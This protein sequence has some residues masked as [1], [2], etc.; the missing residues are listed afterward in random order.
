MHP[1]RRSSRRTCIPAG[2]A[3]EG[4]ASLQEEQ[5]KDMHLCRRSSRTCIS[6]GRALGAAS[7]QQEQRDVHWCRRSAGTCIPTR[8]V[9]GATL[10]QNPHPR[11]RSSR[12]TRIPAGGAAGHASPQEHRQDPQQH[13]STWISTSPHPAALLIAHRRWEAAEPRGD[14]SAE[15]GRNTAGVEREERLTFSLWMSSKAASSSP[16]FLPPLSTGCQERRGA[17]CRLGRHTQR[18]MNSSAP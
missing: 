18:P 12:G 8:G 6:V 5:Q 4:H 13:S 9:A 17:R 1:C 7:L 15:N 14:N 3:A 16:T 11:H 2:G 10:V